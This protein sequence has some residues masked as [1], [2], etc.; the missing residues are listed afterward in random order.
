MKLVRLED[1]CVFQTVI[2]GRVDNRQWKQ[3]NSD[4]GEVAQ[5]DCLDA[6]FF[7]V[8]L[9]NFLVGRLSEQGDGSHVSM[10]TEISW[11]G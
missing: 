9:C 11:Y 4:E 5:L 6:I 10:Q 7:W 2:V 1:F 8:G 3:I